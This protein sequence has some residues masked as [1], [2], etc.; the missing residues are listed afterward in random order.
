M[1]L[2]FWYGS[3]SPFSWRVWL[4]LEHKQAPYQQKTISFQ[5][6]DHMKP[7]FL[8]MNPRHQVP[9]IVDDGFSLYESTAI[10]EYLDERYAEGP[11][12]YPGDLRRR[13]TIRRLIR[14]IDNYL[15]ASYEEL[16]SQIFFTPPDKWDLAAIEKGKK[17]M[18]EEL[19]TLDR[20]LEKHQWL[21][22]D[23]LTAADIA[24]GPFVFSIARLEKRNADLAMTE[25]LPPRVAA[26]KQRYQSL[27]YYEKTIPPHWKS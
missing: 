3:G 2:E 19:G 1:T 15:V 7:E 23:Q 18:L 27:P 5:A 6:G 26:W 17:G 20:L 22:G 24:L 21:A 13:A 10:L 9:V 12:L 11:K 8:A 14:E 25:K 16:T 4:A